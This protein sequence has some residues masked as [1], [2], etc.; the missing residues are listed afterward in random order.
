M[1]I[2]K[3]GG[4]L[5]VATAMLSLSAIAQAE[6][7][8]AIADDIVEKAFEYGCNYGEFHFYDTGLAREGEWTWDSVWQW[9]GKNGDGCKVHLGLISQLYVPQGSPPKG[10]GNGKGYRDAKGAANA[11]RD[12]KPVDAYYHLQNVI[13]TIDNA[14]KLNED[15]EVEVSYGGVPVMV[16]AD[17]FEDRL[18]Q[19]AVDTQELIYNPDTE[20]VLCSVQ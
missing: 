13:D 20:E 17:Y 8:S 5:A 11:L 14:A 19:F 7:C 9:K 15:L 12:E 2:K 4:S 1:N 3:I 18:R 6:E 16:R 10:K